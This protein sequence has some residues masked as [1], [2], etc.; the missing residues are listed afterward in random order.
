QTIKTDIFSNIKGK[1]DIIFANPPYIPTKKSKVQ[2]SVKNWEPKM[3]LYAGTDGLAIIKKFLKEAKNHLNSQGKIY[4]EFG[5]GQ[6]SKIEKLLK[7][8]GY[9]NWQFNKDQFGKYRW[10]VIE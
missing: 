3:A 10:V 8:Y 6:K 2:K 4:L 9:S 7:T 5:F 1:F